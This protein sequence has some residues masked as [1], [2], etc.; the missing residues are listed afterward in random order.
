MRVELALSFIGRMRP[1]T[2]PV[3]IRVS[4]RSDA[5]DLKPGDTIS[6]RAVLM[7]P[8]APDDYDFGRATYCLRIGAL[9]YAYG[10]PT[11][12]AAGHVDCP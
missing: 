3:K 4:I 1:Q 12:I 10:K 2:M 9:S 11:M 5:E 8:H 6:L 7:P